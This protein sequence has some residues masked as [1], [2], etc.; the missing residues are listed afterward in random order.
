MFAWNKIFAHL[1]ANRCNHNCTYVIRFK[2]QK[3]FVCVIGAMELHLRKSLIVYLIKLSKSCLVCIGKCTP[4]LCVVTYQCHQSNTGVVNLSRHIVNIY[5]WVQYFDMTCGSLMICQKWGSC[6]ARGC[7]SI[8]FDICY[9]LMTTCKHRRMLFRNSYF[10]NNM[11]IT[12][13]YDGL[14]VSFQSS[15]YR[16]N[17]NNHTHT[18]VVEL[19]LIK[20]NHAA[21]S[22]MGHL[23]EYRSSL[24]WDEGG[25]KWLN[26]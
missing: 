6:A 11:S 7:S 23:Y 5:H 9:L 19:K 20:K 12:W 8:C 4:L 1:T 25:D 16:F 18:N 22:A 24:I 26:Q 14:C 10:I 13:K 3:K 21:K 17:S 15:F 2:L